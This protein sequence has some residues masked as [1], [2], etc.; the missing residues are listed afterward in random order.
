MSIIVFILVCVSL[1]VS[2]Q[3]LGRFIFLEGVF[4]LI[5]L[6]L[7]PE[8]YNEDVHKMLINLLDNSLYLR[9]LIGDL[10]LSIKKSW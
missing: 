5:H 4:G 6:Y 9:N 8:T 1:N 10:C 7:T 2:Y 3:E